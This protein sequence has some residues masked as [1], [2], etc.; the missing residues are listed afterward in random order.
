[1]KGIQANHGDFGTTHCGWRLLLVGGVAPSLPPVSWLYTQH[2][3]QELQCSTSVNQHQHSD[4]RAI[5]G[6][7]QQI[8]LLPHHSDT[9]LGAPFGPLKITLVSLCSFVFDPKGLHY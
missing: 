2:T 1:M 4:K 7:F 5:S 8:V 6:S 9:I 3:Q